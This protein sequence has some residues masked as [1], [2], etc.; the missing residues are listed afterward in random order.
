MPESSAAKAVPEKVESLSRNE[1]SFFLHQLADRFGLIVRIDNKSGEILKIGESSGLNRTKK[2]H[3]AASRGEPVVQENMVFYVDESLAGRGGTARKNSLERIDFGR[4]GLEPEKNNV[5]QLH[6]ERSVILE[7]AL[8]L[9]GISEQVNWDDKNNGSWLESA[10]EA[11]SQLRS[12]KKIKDLEP[13]QKK[14]WESL[15]SSQ[16]EAVVI[17]QEIMKYY[18]LS[19]ESMFARDGALKTIGGEKLASVIQDLNNRQRP[20]LLYQSWEQRYHDWVADQRS[21]GIKENLEVSNWQQARYKQYKNIV[22]AESKKP[23]SFSDWQAG[24][25]LEQKQKYQPDLL[26]IEEGGLDL[27]QLMAHIEFKRMGDVVH[28]CLSTAMENFLNPSSGGN[29]KLPVSYATA[30]ESGRVGLIFADYFDGRIHDVMLNALRASGDFFLWEAVGRFERMLRF[31]QAV[32]GENRISKDAW[33]ALEGLSS[34]AVQFTIL[35]NKKI[36]MG[37]AKALMLPEIVGSRDWRTGRPG[38]HS[39]FNHDGTSRPPAETEPMA[40]LVP[41]ARLRESARLKLEAL[42]Y[43]RWVADLAWAHSWLSGEG[44]DIAQSLQKA[45]TAGE[46]YY[47]IVGAAVEPFYTYDAKLDSLKD[48]QGKSGWGREYAAKILRWLTP[49]AIPFVTMTQDSWKLMSLSPW[50]RDTWFAAHFSRMPAYSWI[51]GQDKERLKLTMEKMEFSGPY[52]NIWERYLMEMEHREQK[53]W[54]TYFH[55]LAGKQLMNLG[56]LEGRFERPVLDFNNSEH[57][58]VLSNLIIDGEMAG[59]VKA[60]LKVLGVPSATVDGWTATDME[61]IIS[62][63]N[64]PTVR[65]SAN[66]L[67][68]QWFDSGEPEIE[69][70][71]LAAVMGNRDKYNRWQQS[72]DPADRQ[73]WIDPAAFFRSNATTTQIA[74]KLELVLRDLDSWGQRADMA[75]PELMARLAGMGEKLD[76]S[77]ARYFFTGHF[78]Y[79]DYSQQYHFMDSFPEMDNPLDPKS[80][81]QNMKF[82]E[83]YSARTGGLPHVKQLYYTLTFRLWYFKQLAQIMFEK[84]PGVGPDQP[85]GGDP[86]RTMFDPELRKKF[87]EILES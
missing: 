32:F 33:S 87:A 11:A 30:A 83:E 37:F 84:T 81:E 44:I 55:L 46:F 25:N 76:G 19:P 26:K 28:A 82:F 7:G 51:S 45:R 48:N 63:L 39:K 42:G 57:V 54:G 50:M 64:S 52:K 59:K 72:L 43:P 13:K 68:M 8:E 86:N 18:G 77:L 75:R 85:R 79:D 35:A 9:E 29:D 70:E 58:Q 40:E 78:L 74:V 56:G 17:Y 67:Q 5:D 27:G 53:R 15:G 3:N 12:G 14:A 21:E 31:T 34:P 38:M 2:I 16:Q 22:E 71:K 4:F 41:N 80:V 66:T 10:W 47:F 69:T 62:Q 49:A 6:R 60:K 36:G 24:D 23:I 1:E 73:P 20:P 61:G 65:Q